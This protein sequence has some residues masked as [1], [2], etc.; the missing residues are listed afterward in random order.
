MSPCYHANL[1]F[2]TFPSR[3]KACLPIYI[4]YQNTL[5]YATWV[6]WEAVKKWNFKYK[7][8]NLWYFKIKFLA[9]IIIIDIIIK[10]ELE[11]SLS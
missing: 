5:V 7:W 11:I 1:L 4:D 2:I 3:Q 6:D 10:S 9:C 8:E